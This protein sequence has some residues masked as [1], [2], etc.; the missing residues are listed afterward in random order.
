MTAPR[1]TLISQ[2]I[3]LPPPPGV[4]IAANYNTNNS[5]F[6]GCSVNVDGKAVF[7]FQNRQV[8]PSVCAT[9]RVNDDLTFA[10]EAELAVSGNNLYGIGNTVTVGTQ[11]F[12]S[13][14][15]WTGS[16]YGIF[17]TEISSALIPI[18][19]A[20]V[21]D[22][23]T[24]I[25]PDAHLNTNGTD[26]FLTTTI[27]TFI[28][29]VRLNTSLTMLA[30]T[31]MSNPIPSQDRDHF[32]STITASDGF[33]YVGGVFGDPQ[34]S[35]CFEKLNATTLA[36]VNRFDIVYN[37]TNF[38]GA[39]MVYANNNL[40]LMT[41]IRNSS[42]AYDI[43]ALV[44]D[45]GFTSFK[46]VW[47]EGNTT[48]NAFQFS[49]GATALANGNIAALYARRQNG[50]N[51][52]F[53]IV[54]YDSNLNVLNQFED[55]NFAGPSTGALNHDGNELIACLNVTEDFINLFRFAEF[56]FPSAAE[57]LCSSTHSWQN[58]SMT[59]SSTTGTPTTRAV[60][61]QTP[62][63]VASTGTVTSS[64]GRGQT[65]NCEFI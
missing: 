6:L 39:N 24:D 65:F 37:Q 40:Y 48:N 22:F 56:D 1:R 60:S 31:R 45:D 25:L 63:G 47:S 23:T 17:V 59:F 52:R 13:T 43:G 26:I 54:I 5:R 32:G 62:A 49:L 35:C 4:N 33:L 64:A 61:G 20:F 7:A 58:T 8:S 3:G 55:V 9:I 2:Q 50:A 36:T 28:E 30:N 16:S 34:Y 11:H 29:V 57:P 46:H 21:Y 42:N 53:Q 44:V 51:P 41:I 10:N 18:G 19:T 27:G 38:A 14:P 12:L 15:Y